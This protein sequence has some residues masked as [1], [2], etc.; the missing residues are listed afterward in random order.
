MQASLA[1]NFFYSDSSECERAKDW[2]GSRFFGNSSGR[3]YV[4]DLN[5]A[6]AHKHGGRIHPVKAIALPADS[7]EGPTGLH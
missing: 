6:A 7:E 1:Y 4:D 5:I 2:W 3:T